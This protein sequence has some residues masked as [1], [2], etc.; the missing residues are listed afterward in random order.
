MSEHYGIKVGTI[1]N[2]IDKLTGDLEYL[3]SLV[4]QPDPEFSL[5]NAVVYSR[6]VVALYN[7]LDFLIEDISE[8]MLSKDEEHVR[9][10]KEDIVMLT[11][12][13]E[14]TEEALEM[15]EDLC[16]ISLQNN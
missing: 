14:N 16:G 8:N 1:L 4:E 12:Y 9:L 11:Q 3:C 15:L 7:Q 5:P 2:A 10:S 6:A 13:T